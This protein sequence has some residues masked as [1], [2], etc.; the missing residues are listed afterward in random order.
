[1]SNPFKMKLPWMLSIGMLI[2]DFIRV[3]L[4]YAGGSAVDST[5]IFAFTQFIP[6]LLVG[7]FIEFAIFFLIGWWVQNMIEKDVYKR[8]RKQNTINQEVGLR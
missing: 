8:I 3:L 1:M 7:F 2:L 4:R 6:V 5:E